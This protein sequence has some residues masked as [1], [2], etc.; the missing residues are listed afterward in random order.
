MVLGDDK[1]LAAFY[2][3]IIGGGAFDNLP[4]SP[5]MR[6]E[7]SSRISEADPMSMT[8][9]MILDDTP[10]PTTA[11]ALLPKE[12]AE[13]LAEAL[14]RFQSSSLSNVT[15]RATSS[16]APVEHTTAMQ[17][18]HAAPPGR[19]RS[20]DAP[21]EQAA[22][23][24]TAMQ[25]TQ[26]ESPSGPCVN[27]NDASI[28]QA[29]LDETAMQTTQAGTDDTAIHT[30]AESASGPSGKVNDAQNEQA[31]ADETAMHTQAE[32]ESGPHE[33]QVEPSTTTARSESAPAREARASP[34]P[35]A[36]NAIRRRRKLLDWQTTTVNCSAD[37]RESE[38]MV[39]QLVGMHWTAHS[40]RAKHDMQLTD[41]QLLGREECE[42]M[43]SEKKK[44]RL[45][46]VR[47]S[48]SATGAK[49][50]YNSGRPE[51][52]ELN[53]VLRATTNDVFREE[54]RKWGANIDVLTETLFPKT[55]PKPKR[56]APSSDESDTE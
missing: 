54:L 7:G 34:T 1:A 42:R 15:V 52:F 45:M 44:I 4:G 31:A 39:V 51:R 29:D 22:S 21:T 35:T 46:Y 14:R 10:P 12:Q 23:E 27:V 24:A 50:T 30:Q 25:T 49:R 18:M 20:A 8:E 6:S 41:L 53:F 48:T 36:R 11:T 56:T 5:G 13:K 28:E 55:K 43:K 38:T 19:P 16:E 2:Q 37:N 9:K 40:S 26:A 17:T 32:S 33:A 47:S 3:T